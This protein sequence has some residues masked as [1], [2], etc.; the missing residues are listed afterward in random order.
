MSIIG[1]RAHRGGRRLLLVTA[2]VMG[3]TIVT[4][5]P[6]YAYIARAYQESDYASV[7][8]D[9]WTVEVCDMEND[10]RGVYGVFATDG[11]GFDVGDP[12]GSAGGCGNRTSPGL[13]RVRSVMVCETRPKP[14]YVDDACGDRV[15]VPR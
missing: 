5:T 8:E 13:F 14:P 1:N 2:A 7:G 15:F 12:N 11:G 4:S 9:G 3:L 6:A 10:G